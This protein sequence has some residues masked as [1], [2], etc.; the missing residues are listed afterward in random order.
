MYC[1]SPKGV[2]IQES[3]QTLDTRRLQ[4]YPWLLYSNTPS[5]M[6]REC[7]D[8]AF[9]KLTLTLDSTKKKENDT[10]KVQNQRCHQSVQLLTCRC[11]WSPQDSC[12]GDFEPD[13]ISDVPNQAKWDED[14]I[15]AAGRQSCDTIAMMTM[16]ATWSWCVARRLGKD[17]NDKDAS[18]TTTKMGCHSSWQIRK[19]KWWLIWQVGCRHARL[20]RTGK[21]YVDLDWYC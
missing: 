10:S 15:T 14:K 20:W 8:V 11:R 12:F 21:I 1:N 6:Q 5:Q 3:T 16:K 2:Y 4:Y 9:G 19:R 17:Q 13:E 7:N 18:T